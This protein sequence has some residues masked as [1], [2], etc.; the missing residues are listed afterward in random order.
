MSRSSP[1]PWSH[2]D[3]RAAL[4]DAREL[5]EAFAVAKG[6]GFADVG[7]QWRCLDTG[8]DVLD[9]VCAFDRSRLIDE[10]RD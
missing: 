9:L 7:E 10:A 5:W 6:V 4:G 1:L 8:D 3:Q 2:V